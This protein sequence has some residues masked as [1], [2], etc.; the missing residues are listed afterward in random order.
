LQTDYNAIDDPYDLIFHLLSISYLYGDYA[1]PFHLMNTSSQVYLSIKKGDV[2]ALRKFAFRNW[3][4]MELLSEEKRQE[5]EQIYQMILEKY[6]D[7]IRAE[8]APLPTQFLTE[9]GERAVKAGHFRDAYSAFKAINVLDKKVNESVGEA[10]QILKSKDVTNPDSNDEATSK[11]VLKQKITQAVILVY[12]AIKLKNPFGNQF[13]KL[14]HQLHYEDADAARKYSKYVE[15]TLVK[16]ILEF[17]IQFLIDDRNIGEKIIN[18]LS[19]SKVKRM[20]LKYMAIHFSGGEER[21][22]KFVENYQQA[23]EKLNKSETEKDFLEVQ[24]ILLG[25][26]TGDNRYFQYLRELSLEHPISALLVSTQTTPTAEFFIAPLILKSGASLL[27]FL[28]IN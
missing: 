12:Q 19:S 20:F 18:A 11:A 21:Y 16:E 22:A 9:L 2:A 3:I 27:D 7:Q 14:G 10:I 6:S 23:V 17:G 4:D 26:G 24:K 25:R 8:L 5:L 15:L 1:I 28:E 13:Q